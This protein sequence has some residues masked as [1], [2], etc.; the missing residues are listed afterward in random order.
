MLG[1]TILLG[2]SAV[3]AVNAFQYGY[4]HVPVRKDIPLV[5]AN[6]KDVDI[7]LYAPAFLDP[8]S[9]QAGFKN[10]TQ[11]PT[12]H[13]DIGMHISEYSGEPTLT[14][15]RG[16]YGKHCFKERLHDLSNS[17]LYI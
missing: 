13:E 5:A 2:I 1:K 7:D 12:S 10:G 11:G 14:T 3:S 17:K 6:F 9:I 4:N 16:L 8:E 15:C